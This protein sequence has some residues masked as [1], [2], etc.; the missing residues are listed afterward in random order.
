MTDK[1]KIRAAWF[2]DQPGADQFVID[3]PTSLECG[4]RGDVATVEFWFDDDGALITFGVKKKQQAS[5][6]E[7]PYEHSMSE[8]SSLAAFFERLADYT[9]APQHAQHTVHVDRNECFRIAEALRIA[10]IVR[11]YASRSD[12]RND[13]PYP[14]SCQLVL[15]LAKKRGTE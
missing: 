11:E 5:T 1:E 14:G 9:F 12:V 8:Q 6:P 3:K 10:E 4:L 2:G 15:V 7:K 13:A